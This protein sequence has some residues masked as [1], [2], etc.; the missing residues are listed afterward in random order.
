MNILK[1]KC[2]SLVVLLIE[3]LPAVTLRQR[4]PNQ[5]FAANVKIRTLPHLGSTIAIDEANWWPQSDYN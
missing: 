1:L 4:S 5:V 3:M 2:N